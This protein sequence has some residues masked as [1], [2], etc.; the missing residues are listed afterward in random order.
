MP[1]LR[2]P[3][4]SATGFLAPLLQHGY[5]LERSRVLRIDLQSPFEV[6]PR[7]GRIIQRDAQESTIPVGVGVLIIHTQGFVYGGL[8]RVCV[9]QPCFNKTD[10]GPGLSARHSLRE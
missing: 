3:E 4:D 8:R 5:S 7:R 1:I 2:M 6:T 10:F 9:A